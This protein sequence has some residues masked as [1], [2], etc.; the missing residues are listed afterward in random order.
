MANKI[1]PTRSTNEKFM[2]KILFILIFTGILA[3]CDRSDSSEQK[4]TSFIMPASQHQ[5]LSHV[6]IVLTVEDVNN[7][8]ASTPAF[9]VQALKEQGVKGA[10]NLTYTWGDPDG[11]LLIDSNLLQF[12]TSEA[13]KRNLLGD[14]GAE[15]PD[16]TQKLTGIGDAA[17]RVN[18]QT[19]RFVSEN[20][21]VTLTSISEDV[22]LEEVAIA[23]AK[24]LSSK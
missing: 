4:V 5:E 19:I 16:G 3:G 9:L 17:I 2:K 24:W 15:L 21:K 14:S 13:A 22:K 8:S 6:E 10:V 20:I 11:F 12:A 18:N 23:Y 1:A 7:P